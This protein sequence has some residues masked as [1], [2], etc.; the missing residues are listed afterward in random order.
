[1]VMCP[2]KWPGNSKEAG[3]TYETGS[4]EESQQSPIN[5]EVEERKLESNQI[6]MIEDQE[7]DLRDFQEIKPRIV[8][9]IN[10]FCHSRLQREHYFNYS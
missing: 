7:T 9:K 1:M 4:K 5:P 8:G 10:D 3:W 6:N 2:L